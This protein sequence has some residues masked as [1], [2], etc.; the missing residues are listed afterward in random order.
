MRQLNKFTFNICSTVSL[1]N[2]INLLSNED[3]KYIFN[4]FQKNKQIISCVDYFSEIE[5]GECHIYSCPYES[6][7]YHKITNNFPGG[8]FKHVHEISLFDEQP[9]EHKFFFQISQSFPFMKKLTLINE[10]PSRNLH[11]N[12]EHLSIIEYPHLSQ[13]DLSEA[14]DDYIE[15]FLVDTKISLSNSFYLCCRLSK[16]L[17]RVTQHFA[18][19]TTR[20]NCSKVRSLCLIGKCR[21]PEHMKNIM[22]VINVCFNKKC[23]RTD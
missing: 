21:I 20:I 23:L 1:H 18:R 10:K 9:F 11:D 7:E 17:K 15:Q 14:Q 22:I 4:E 16:V 19:N 6:K 13:L 12:N 3:I 8:I 5:R 2:Q